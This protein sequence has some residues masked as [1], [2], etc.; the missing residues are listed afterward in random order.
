MFGPSGIAAA[1]AARL[2]EWDTVLTAGVTTGNVVGYVRSIGMG[3]INPDEPIFNEIDLAGLF[4]NPA[5]DE[6]AFTFDDVTV[7]NTDDSFITLT[8]TGT[9]ANGASTKVLQRSDAVYTTPGFD[10]QWN[11][12]VG[13]DLMLDGNIY[14][15]LVER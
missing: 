6:L 2:T 3:S 5:R 4:T 14:Q 10:T 11:W 1:A 12:D 15:V 9:F 7:P 13:T 8:V